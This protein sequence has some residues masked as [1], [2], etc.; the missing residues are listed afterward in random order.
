MGDVLLARIVRKS[1]ALAVEP[2][3]VERNRMINIVLLPLRHPKHLEWTLPDAGL[4]LLD[5]IR[6]LAM[7]ICG[8]DVRLGGFCRDTL[9]LYELPSANKMLI[10]EE[11]GYRVLDLK[12]MI[13]FFIESH[14]IRPEGVVLINPSFLIGEKPDYKRLVGHARRHG[15]SGSA[16][17]TSHD[18]YAAAFSVDY[19]ETGGLRSSICRG[20][21][22]SA[23]MIP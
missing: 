22:R 1:S 16:M 17:P 13:E 19:I 3:P 18:V 6:T 10:R 14:P 8:A 2:R 20:C 21:S 23:Y 5:G 12:P 7:G 15:L 11:L 9:R 4:V